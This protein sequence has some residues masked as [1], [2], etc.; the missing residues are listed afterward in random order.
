MISAIGQPM[1]N[2]IAN[3][4][5]NPNLNLFTLSSKDVP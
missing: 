4:I 1:Q 2:K 3:S 5:A